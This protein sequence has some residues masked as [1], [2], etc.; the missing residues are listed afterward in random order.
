MVLGRSGCPTASRRSVVRA[1]IAIAGFLVLVP[2]GPAVAQD[3]PPSEP[4]D[5]SQPVVTAVPG[6]PL[7]D[8]GASED[9]DPNTQPDGSPAPDPGTDPAENC[10][11]P[12]QSDPG[13][14][15]PADAC[16][17]KPRG[18]YA[19]Q[20]PFVPDALNRAQV[21]RVE[22]QLAAARAA[23]VED[24][25]RVR[26]LRLRD[27]R[28]ALERAELSAETASTVDA[29]E[30]TEEQLRRRALA[31][32]VV[33]DSFEL[34]PSLEHDDIL[35]FQQHRFL[36]GEVLS[37]DQDLVDEYTRLRNRLEYE[38]LELYDRINNTRRWLRSAREQADASQVEVEALEF[39]LATWQNRSAVFVS[40]V[41]FPID[42]PYD[43]PLINSWGYPR[44]P[45]TIDE[46]WHEG[47]DIFAPDGTPLVAAEGGTVTDIGVGTLGGLK[48]WV[49][50]DSGTRWY[51]A[52]LSAFNPE[53]SVGDVV[54]AGDL[55]GYVGA[56]GNAVGTP[57]HLHLQMHPDGGR[58]VNPY[59]ILQAASE[60]YQ[61][62]QLVEERMAQLQA[63]ALAGLL[64]N[65]MSVS[66]LG[67]DVVDGADPARVA[68]AVPVMSVVPPNVS[69]AE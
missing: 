61:Q 60:I 40:D 21:R 5:D 37:L 56:T 6:D 68:G 33:G 24:V 23:L 20:P 53:L 35:R 54:A 48:I 57:P 52:H 11:D 44:A 63:Q 3:D 46:H 67:A 59:P 26:S 32:F 62:E 39:E 42:G 34:A 41:V 38:A 16:E 10:V 29:L 65:G 64:P 22:G 66:Q 18:R 51:Y 8:E 49:L 14:D 30:A 9:L 17:D 31:T 69:A 43:L 47:I 28:L 58:P 25:A 15:Q 12:G 2:A 4:A 55:I 7:V 19:N 27:K 1:V 45:G 13:S 50:G 36:V